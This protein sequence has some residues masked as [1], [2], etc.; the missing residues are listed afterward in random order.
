MDYFVTFQSA[1]RIY[2]LAFNA[3]LLYSCANSY[4]DNARKVVRGCQ[5][6][7]VV[8]SC[9]YN[10]AKRWWYVPAKPTSTSTFVP[11]DATGGLGHSAAKEVAERASSVELMDIKQSETPIVTKIP[12]S[13]DEAVIDYFAS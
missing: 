13:L 7:Y 6:V 12:A 4:Y 1:Q 8:S 11:K 3:Y 9:T 10:K 2:I 5:T